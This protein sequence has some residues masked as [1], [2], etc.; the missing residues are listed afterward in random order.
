MRYAAEIAYKGTHYHGWQ[1]QPNGVTVQQMIEAVLEKIL[2]VRTPIM[3]CGRTDAGVHATAFIFHFDYAEE[4]PIQ[5]ILRMNQNL[6]DDIA[7]HDAFLVADNF[8]SRFH[9][10]YRKYIYKVHY[11]KNPFLQESSLF[12]YKV[13]ELA[14]MN[15]AC[16]VLLK[17]K[18]FASFCKSGADNKTTLC[19]LMLAEWI[20]TDV[21]LEFHVQANRFLRNM[22]RALVG[23]MLDVGYGRTS[24]EQMEEIIASKHRSSSGKSV[25]AKG[26]YLAEIG[27]NWNE[28]KR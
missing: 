16:E 19:D 23:T 4:L 21:G 8:H 18:D 2:Q 9:A 14:P 11:R 27:Y 24:L 5:F 22:V 7:C 6:P 10:T 20:E 28:Y 15:A 13:P 17:T 12:L 3:G 25:A 26:L 1:S